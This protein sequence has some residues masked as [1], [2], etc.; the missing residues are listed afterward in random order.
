MKG[1]ILTEMNF[2]NVPGYEY[3]LRLRIHW[4]HV[5]ASL[6]VASLTSQQ[7]CT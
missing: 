4:L 1:Y 5:A 6:T 3:S 2:G 7:N